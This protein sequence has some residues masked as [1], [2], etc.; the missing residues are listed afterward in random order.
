MKL[1]SQ[2]LIFALV[3]AIGYVPSEGSQVAASRRVQAAAEQP[4]QADLIRPRRRVHSTPG[5]A[6]TDGVNRTRRRVVSA[7][8]VPVPEVA[9]PHGAPM[10]QAQLQKLPQSEYGYEAFPQQ[11]PVS[12]A[13]PMSQT[14]PTIPQSV[15]VVSPENI[16]PLTPMG[17]AELQVKKLNEFV[18]DVSQ[19]GNIVM[20]PDDFD[21][22]QK[23][24]AE[25][26]VAL[27]ELRAALEARENALEPKHTEDTE[28]IKGIMSMAFSKL[29]QGLFKFVGN[30]AWAPVAKLLE[31]FGD[32]EF[33]ARDQV[34]TASNTIMGKIAN[35]FGVQFMKKR[36][37]QEFKNAY[38][39]AVNSL[40]ND[41]NALQKVSTWQDIYYRALFKIASFNA[42]DMEEIQGSMDKD[43]LKR[44]ESMRSKM[45]DKQ[46]TTID[47]TKKKAEVILSMLLAA[48]SREMNEKIGVCNN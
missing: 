38:D 26:S 28:K 42:R 11:V 41:Q 8:P 20:N 34:L 5:V 32:A 16:D 29:R 3:L 19:T 23:T 33:K 10:S 30:D 9:F 36:V 2:I 22:I 13:A 17:N 46:T 47:D 15:N 44:V 7:P 12:Q 21:G 6:T 4:G 45:G 14:Q 43:M 48:R 31:K 39:G 35:E 37:G 24:A 40:K 18:R 27:N 1:T 25:A